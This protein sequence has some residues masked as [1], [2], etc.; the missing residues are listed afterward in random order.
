MLEYGNIVPYVLP[1]SG[2]CVRLPTKRNDFGI[3]MELVGF[4]VHTEMDPRTPL[5]DVARD[6]DRIYRGD[7]A[8]S[9]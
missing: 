4:P 2:L 3:P 5:D 1:D 6:F 8:I 7:S 9:P